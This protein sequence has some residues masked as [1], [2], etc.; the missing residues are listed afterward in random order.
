[1][2]SLFIMNITLLSVN[3]NGLIDAKMYSS[4]PQ[5]NHILIIYKP[6]NHMCHHNLVNCVL[7]SCLSLLTS[8]S[9]NNMLNII[10]EYNTEDVFLTT[11][12]QLPLSLFTTT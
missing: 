9:A 6:H 1:M 2:C 10:S 3:N 12:A 11:P 4:Q 5:P 8:D 7:P